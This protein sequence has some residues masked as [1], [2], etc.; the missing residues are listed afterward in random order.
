MILA[1]ALLGLLTYV[2]TS[3][4]QVA[5]ITDGSMIPTAYP[6]DRVLV[7]LSAYGSR[8]PQ[9]GDLV[10]TDADPGRDR[11]LKR[12]IGV[13]GDVVTIGY[14]VVLVNG[15][16]L[17]EPYVR[18]AMLPEE[19]LRVEVGPGEVFL[20]GDNRN[21]SQDSRD[22]GPVPVDELMGRVRY[23]FLPFSRAGRLG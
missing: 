3:V 21:I 19:P 23:R 8:P 7:S 20:M 17:R 14:G 18:Q 11:V 2:H 13:E 16:L 4:V 12:V 9:R 22:C 5:F 6:G 1:G 10:V 15:G